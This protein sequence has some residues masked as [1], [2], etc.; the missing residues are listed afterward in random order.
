LQVINSSPGDL[1]PVFDAMLEKGIR[2]CEAAFGSLWTYDG[3]CFHAVAIRNVPTALTE[4]VRQPHLAGPNTPLGRV[5]RTKKLVSIADLAADEMYLSGDQI[6]AAPVVLGGARSYLAV[7]LLKDTALVGAFAVSRREVRPFTDKQIALL[8]NFAT[9]AVIAMENAR[10]INETREALEQQTA[11]AEVLQ[12]INSSPGDLAPVFDAMLQKATRLCDAPSAIFWTVEGE[13]ARA[14]AVHG[15]PDRYA[16]HLRQPIPLDPATGLG[17]V[18]QGDRVA[19]SLDVAAEEPYQAGNPRPRA[20][21]DFGKARSAV[22]VPLM[23]DAKLLGIL[24][25]YR[26]EVRPFTDKQIALLQN[27]AAQAVIAMENA[28]LLGELR[29]RTAELVRSVEELQLLGEVGQAVSSAL[30]V[31]TV[32]STI[33]TRSVG[34]TGADAGAV[35]RYRPADHSFSLVEAVG[36]GR[37]CCARSA[38]GTSSR[39]K[40]RWVTRRRNARRSRSPISK[41]GR[42][43]RYVT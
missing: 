6:T 34:M 28:R 14:A 35:F 33:L 31:R 39:T 21:V 17:Q 43:R 16:E 22:R 10:L 5:A 18:L 42:A 38:S 25:V 4:F 7:P 15:I 19:V 12:V 8:Q 13:F 27:F 23:K 37:R 41:S 24:T 11:T 9:Q 29:A 32:L 30:D 3:D 1:A 20:F 2:L 36:W 26:Q 40:P